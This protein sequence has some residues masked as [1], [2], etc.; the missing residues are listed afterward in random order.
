MHALCNE[1]CNFTGCRIRNDSSHFRT[2]FEKER[3]QKPSQSR[4]LH[5]VR[6]QSLKIYRFRKIRPGLKPTDLSKISKITIPDSRLNYAGKRPNFPN[7]HRLLSNQENQQLNRSRATDGHVAQWLREH[8]GRRGCEPP[9]R[10]KPLWKVSNEDQVK[11]GLN[12]KKISS[13]N[14]NTCHTH[15]NKRPQLDSNAPEIGPHSR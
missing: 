13:S 12:L 14:R 10:T 3:F 11:G 8:L 2:Y 7:N 6:I 15:K 4:R 1:N 9:S 5:L